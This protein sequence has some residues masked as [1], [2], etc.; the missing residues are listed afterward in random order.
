MVAV[1]DPELRCDWRISRTW[2]IRFRATCGYSSTFSFSNSHLLTNEPDAPSSQKLWLCL[3]RPGES[4]EKRS[5]LPPNGD[6]VTPAKP[7]AESPARRISWSPINRNSRARMQ[8]SVS[9]ARKKRR[10][11]VAPFVVQLFVEVTV[12]IHQEHCHRLFGPGFAMC[13]DRCFR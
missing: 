4:V 7:V 9:V 8:T 12:R 3:A 1:R 6:V 2:P 11:N 5:R 10:D 13:P